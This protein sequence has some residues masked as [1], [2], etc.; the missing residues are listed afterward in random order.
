M[1]NIKVISKQDAWNKVNQIFP[2][3]DGHDMQSSTCADYPVYRGTAEGHYYYD[4]ICDMGDRLEVNMDSS[5]LKTATSGL[6]NQPL[7]RPPALLS[8]SNAEKRTKQAVNSM[9]YSVHSY[10]LTI[11]W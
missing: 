11:M 10:K 5:H 9:T 3:D 2:T 6:R 8:H 7:R 1:A 4:Y